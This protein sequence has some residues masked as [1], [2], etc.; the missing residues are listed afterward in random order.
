MSGKHN[1]VRGTIKVTPL[2]DVPSFASASR[3]ASDEDAIAIIKKN[4]IAL[5]SIAL[6]GDE[7]VDED[8]DE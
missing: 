7:D 4:T 1:V 8:D 3:L 2:P 5:S 6:P